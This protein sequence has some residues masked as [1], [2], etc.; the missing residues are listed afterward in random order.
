MND[1]MPS[2]RDLPTL[3][4]SEWTSLGAESPPKSSAVLAAT[5]RFRIASGDLV[6]GDRLP[7]EDD[8]MEQFGV[9]RTTMREA[10]RILEV[11]GLITIRRGRG[12]GPTV[13]TPPV[14]RLANGFAVH[15][16][17]QGTTIGD[18]HDARKVIEPAIAA[19][20]ARRHT[21]EDLEALDAAIDAAAV[22]AQEG[23]VKAFGAAAATF[24]STITDRAENNTL[25]L[26]AAMLRE[27]VERFYIELS[28]A[29]DKALMHRAVQSYR[30][31]LHLIEDG[32]EAGAAE[33]WRRH[34]ILSVTKEH[35]ARPLA[36]INPRANGRTP[37]S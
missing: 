28:A 30:K 17:L 29:G 21:K 12:G 22:A 18:L 25:G 13:T 23:D 10:L 33:H 5:L 24:H 37:S 20:L 1:Y 34:M 11:E 3:S 15:L 8:L 7:S 31:L 19:H 32:D 16:Q 14:D 26:M 35:R 36:M 4:P 6:S 27:L 2:R 9:A